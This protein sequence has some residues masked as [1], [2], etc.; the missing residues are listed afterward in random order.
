MLY[1][2]LYGQLFLQPQIKFNYYRYYCLVKT[3][4]LADNTDLRNR[5]PNRI[6]HVLL[7]E[8]TIFNIRDE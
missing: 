3:V 8:L 5:K 4:Y 2:L 6:H 7:P 1:A